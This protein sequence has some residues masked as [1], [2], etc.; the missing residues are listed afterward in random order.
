MNLGGVSGAKSSQD[1]EGDSNDD[2]VP[3]APRAGMFSRKQTES[4]DVAEYWHE[5]LRRGEADLEPAS[6]YLDRADSAKRSRSAP[7]G[8]P[9]NH[10]R[11]LNQSINQSNVSLHY[12][13]PKRSQLTDS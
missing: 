11:C 13:L 4:R 7:R 5:R 2:D 8:A 12:A 9:S 6:A 1:S 10:C 3:L